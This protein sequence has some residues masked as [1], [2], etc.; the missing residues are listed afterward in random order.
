M[1][2]AGRL[3]RRPTPTALAAL[4]DAPVTAGGYQTTFELTQHALFAEDFFTVWR[5]DL[6]LRPGIPPT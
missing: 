6:V 2:R 3:Q 1:R 4:G 5:R